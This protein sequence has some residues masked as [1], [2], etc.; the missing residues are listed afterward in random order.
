MVTEYSV[1]RP[2]FQFGAQPAG[3]D[4]CHSSSLFLVDRSRG[5]LKPSIFLALPPLP[6]KRAPHM[7][8]SR[9]SPAFDPNQVVRA[10]AAASVA[11]VVGGGGHLTGATLEP[12][13][14]PR[15]G[16]LVFL[17]RHPPF[18]SCQL[19]SW[20]ARCAQRCTHRAHGPEYKL[21]LPP[22]A[23]IALHMKLWRGHAGD[24]L[25]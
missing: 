14:V 23:E 15:P 13:D 2:D 12:S 21:R 24:A 5:G 10:R 11:E 19:L 9:G 17:A 25:D 1:S 3:S 22:C 20:V 8:P 16:T 7:P 6:Q 4:S 18:H